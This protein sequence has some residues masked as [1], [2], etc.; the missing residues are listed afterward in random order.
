MRRPLPPIC[1][2]A[3]A[4]L[5]ACVGCGSLDANQGDVLGGSGRIVAVGGASGG[6]QS[7][8]LDGG[9]ARPGSGG[10][11]GAACLPPGASAACSACEAT[12]CTTNAFIYGEGYDAATFDP[13]DP[14]TP[15]GG[16][17]W[18]HLCYDAT[19]AVAAGPMKGVKKSV[20]CPEIVDCVHRSGC[21]A[22]DT[23][24]LPCYCGAGVTIDECSA[25]GFVPKGPCADLIAGGAESNQPLTVGNRAVDYAYAAGA[26]LGLVTLCDYPVVNAFGSTPG[27]CQSECLGGADGGTTSCTM[28][29]TDG[30]APGDGGGS[31]PDADGHGGAGGSGRA[32]GAG[33]SGGGCTTTYR[34]A[35]AAACA[36]CELSSSSDYCNPALLT[37]TV[38][39]D[40]DGNPVA[41]GFG[42][43][44]LATAAQRDAAFAIINR[45][46]QLKCYSD[47]KLLY[48][49]ANMP[50]CETLPS[51][52][53]CIY[54]NLGCLLDLGQ[55]STDIAS[56]NFATMPTY[57]ALAEYEA[58]AIADATVGP[59][60]PDQSPG[61]GAP[62]GIPVGASNATLGTYL[63]L[64]GIH[65]SSA[66]GLA[67]TVLT[68]GL[69]SGCTACFN[70]KATTSCPSGN[71]GST[72]A[73]GAGGAAGSSSAAGASGGSGKGGTS[74]TGGSTGT[75]AA[76][77]S[78][79]SGSTCPDL[80]ADG[81]PDCQQT[82][83][84]NPGFDSATTGWKAEAGS[85]VSWTSQDGR[86]N[87]SSGAV[88]VV[89]SDTNPAD[90]PY[91]T[92]AA[93]AFQCL[94]VTAGSCSQ[95]DAQTLI[96]S[97]QGSVAA[98]FVLDEHTTADCSQPTAL[99]FLSPQVS[100]TGAWQT[101]SGKTTQI[102]LGIGS[103]SV[104]LVAVKPTAQVSAEA[105]FDNLL[106]RV[107][108]C[109][110]P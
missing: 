56:G 83:V 91:G 19:G 86:G 70:L 79:G 8:S 57:S 73:A 110:S 101:V 32:G 31:R 54:P 100:S 6:G 99:S 46:V 63:N 45:V 10:A 98:G 89:N 66:I 4:V 36:S 23:A 1:L 42:P 40:S 13:G 14:Q 55:H 94:A 49:P 11:G 2:A 71:G 84:Q 27:A 62:G 74:G 87:S 17:D 65:P 58:A 82:L 9:A 18:Y 20:L 106:V 41:T 77:G 38:T 15:A 35:D 30:G 59:A 69:N 21:N 48:R 51:V 52:S 75:A 44:T 5:L 90:A 37:A 53:A 16:I 96:P 81:V 33:G 78:G 25:A 43:D 85:T 47:Q 50:G 105:L 102:P 103:M 64:Q 7:G 29:T 26:A 72:G 80:D 68:C 67:D 12:K 28:A 88:A 104:R 3:A 39:Q 108:T 93:G 60:T 61:Y 92:T 34:F 24:N 107:A 95:V 76:P 22:A 97:G 109:A